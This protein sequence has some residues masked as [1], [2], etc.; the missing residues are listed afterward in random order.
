MADD[1]TRTDYALYIDADTETLDHTPR[2]SPRPYPAQTIQGWFSAHSFVSTEDH[3]RHHS[4]HPCRS[5]PQ[6]RTVKLPHKL[7]HWPMHSAIHAIRCTI[8]T[9]VSRVCFSNLP[10][11][12]RC[13][14]AR[15]MPICFS[16]RP[17]KSLSPLLRRQDKI[18]FRLRYLS[19]I[20]TM[21]Q[22]RIIRVIRYATHAILPISQ[23]ATFPGFMSINAY[24][25]SSYKSLNSSL[26]I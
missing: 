3:S 16:H 4:R 21:R 2:R 19:G 9:R 17:N 1:I 18:H 15:C 6:S 7:G 26:V 13:H 20:R 5:R 14:V 25:T 23:R 22:P 12:P 24:V 8:E 11:H 10:A